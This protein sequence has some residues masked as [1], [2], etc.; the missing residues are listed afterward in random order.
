VRLATLATLVT[1]VLAVGCN[2]LHAFE[3][4][5]TGPRVGES[6]VLHVGVAPMA[7]ATLAIDAVDSHGIRGRLSISDIVTESAFQSVEG[8]EAD[9]LSNLSFSGEPMRVYLAFVPMPDDGGDALAVIAL[10]DDKR[11]E[12]RVLRGGTKPLY[13]IFALREG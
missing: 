3:G 7:T 1:I 11:V 6:P 10:Y 9:V 5:W 4:T 2:D 12:V 13:S 8:A